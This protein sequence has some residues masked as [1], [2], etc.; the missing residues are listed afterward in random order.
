MKASK[1]EK[2]VEVRA[3]ERVWEKITLFIER[4]TSALEELSGS[5]Y[6]DM[7]P[8]LE[9]ELLMNVVLSPNKRKWPRI[10]WEAEE[11]QVTKEFLSTMDEIQ[12]AL[13]E[14][15]RESNPEVEK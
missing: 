2:M 9:K 10:L 14:V 7:D 13:I 4:V 1:F 12:K 8:D 3:D 5:S 11:E 6:G 15:E